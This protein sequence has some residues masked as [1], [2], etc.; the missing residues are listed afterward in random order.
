MGTLLFVHGIGGHG[1]GRDRSYALVQ[2]QA[3]RHL[4][5][6]RLEGCDAAGALGAPR[7]P[8]LRALPG[9]GHAPPPPGEAG[10]RDVEALRWRLLYLDPLVEMRALAALGGEPDPRHAPVSPL[11][12]SAQKKST[13]SHLARLHAL[14]FGDELLRDAGLGAA[15]AQALQAQ[16]LRQ[17]AA[18]PR[19]D[20]V[21]MAPQIEGDVDRRQYLARAFVAAWIVAA[22]QAGLP[23]VAGACR[24][25]L[26][27]QAVL[28]LGGAPHK[29]LHDRIGDAL[30]GVAASRGSHWAAR[31]RGMLADDTPLPGELLRYQ[32]RGQAL[33]RLLRRRVDEVQARRPGP[34]LLLAHGVGAVAAFELLNE[35]QAP[36]LAG[37]VTVGSPATCLYE[38]DA[39]A[40]L[41]EG[42]PLPAR[43]PPWLNVHDPA[44]LLSGVAEGL[45]GGR[46]HDVAVE[47]RQPFPQSHGAYWSQPALWTALEGFVH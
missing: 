8:A 45:F 9:H 22:G 14:R 5:A 29:G 21:L 33:R 46:V 7:P 3:A 32:L 19:L 25:R 28:A 1:D 44:D 39:L 36:A 38:L 17:L 6:V 37:L 26:C 43:F 34:L 15:E 10:A 41:R 27:A 12:A 35:A 20:S 31:N 11:A 13:E 18:E 30:Q 23:V 47:S 24:D 42:A 2:Q 40:T 16:A 4:P